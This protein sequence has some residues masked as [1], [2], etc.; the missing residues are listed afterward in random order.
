MEYAD[1]ILKCADCKA[2]F[3]YSA[4]EQLFFYDKQFTNDPKRCKECKAHATLKNEYAP[5]LR[6]FV[7]N[8]ERT[9][10]FHSSYTLLGV[11]RIL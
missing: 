7:L 11:N 5:K 2:E 6:R 9:Q 3:V 4:G 10:Q 1:R 8:L